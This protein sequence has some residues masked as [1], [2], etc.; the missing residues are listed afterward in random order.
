VELEPPVDVCFL[1]VLVVLLDRGATT[2]SKVT[3]HEKD[4]IKIFAILLGVF[5]GL[6]STS[7]FVTAATSIIKLP[8]VEKTLF[9]LGKHLL[10]GE[11]PSVSAVGTASAGAVMIDTSHSKQKGW[12]REDLMH[13]HETIINGYQSDP[14]ST[15]KGIPTT[16]HRYYPANFSYYDFM[17]YELDTDTQEFITSHKRA[18][19]GWHEPDRFLNN[20]RFYLI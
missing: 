17:V 19:S 20:D 3:S 2:N 5:G 14:V 15:N 1:I 12:Y 6:L 10:L 7:T 4:K 18:R 8:F 13:D 11:D 9:G 16:D